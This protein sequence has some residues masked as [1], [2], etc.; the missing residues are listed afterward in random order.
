MEAF[1]CAV[2]RRIL[3][4]RISLDAHQQA[5]GNARNCWM[6]TSAVHG[7]PGAKC[8][9]DIDERRGDASLLRHRKER[10]QHRCN[11][12]PLDVQARG[13]EECDHKDGA[14]IV[15]HRE[16]QQEGANTGRESAAEHRQ[17]RKGEGDIC[18][19]R[20]TP[21]VQRISGTTLIHCDIQE[22]WNDHPAE[23]RRHRQR[24]LARLRERA[25]HQLV[26]ELAAND[27]EEDGEQPIGGPLLHGEVQMERV[28][29]DLGRRNRAQHLRERAVRQEDADEGGSDQQRAAYGLAAKEE[30]H[31]LSSVHACIVSPVGGVGGTR[32]YS[33]KS[34]TCWRSGTGR[35]SSGGWLA[36]LS[37]CLCSRR[38]ASINPVERR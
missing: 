4:A 10:Q 31:A 28:T 21:A 27:E 34:L 1:R 35:G 29:A 25:D 9:G 38:S 26:F 8:K 18:C 33:L 12:E 2:D 20:N 14:K 15:D 7:I 32:P 36:S 30:L 19:H 37:C 13:V 6:N 11:G 3:L 5:E 24:R 17:H 22:R 16:R 23:C